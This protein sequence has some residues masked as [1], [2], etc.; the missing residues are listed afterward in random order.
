M[1]LL[2]QFSELKLSTFRMRLVKRGGNME[3]SQIYIYMFNK[4]QAKWYM[5]V[6]FF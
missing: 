6:N 2:H 3:I 1:T 5:Q 4:T